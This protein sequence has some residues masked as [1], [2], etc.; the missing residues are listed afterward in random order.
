MNFS[1]PQNGA[2][3]ASYINDGSTLGPVGKPVHTPA[4]IADLAFPGKITLSKVVVYT[5]T[6]RA[7]ATPS[8]GLFEVQ[9]RVKHKSGKEGWRAAGWSFSHFDAMTLVL[10]QKDGLRIFK[11][12][13]SFLP[14]ESWRWRL[15]AA[16]DEREDKDGRWGWKDK[17]KEDKLGP[18]INEV[19]FRGCAR[20]AAPTT[21]P[22]PEATDTPRATLT[23]STTA[24]P[25]VSPSLTATLTNT[26]QDTPTFSDSPTP[27]DTRTFTITETARDSATVT[28]SPTV[29]LSATVT[30]T[31]SP[32]PTTDPTPDCSVF[33]PEYTA[34][35]WVGK[36][37]PGD[38]VALLAS[39]G[40]VLGYS[41]NPAQ[42]GYY[43][44]GTVP[45]RRYI[46]GAC[47]DWVDHRKLQM[48]FSDGQIDIPTMDAFGNTLGN[49]G[50]VGSGLDAPAVR[51]IAYDPLDGSLYA[52]ES[53]SGALWRMAPGGGTAVRVAEGLGFC[54]GMAFDSRRNLYVCSNTEGTISRVDVAVNPLSP[55]VT[56]IA[57]GMVQLM[58]LACDGKNNLY[59]T[60]NNQS[61]GQG[62]LYKIDLA[63]GNVQTFTRNFAPL[64]QNSGGSLWM[65]HGVALD[66]AGYIWITQ[67]NT[68]TN[69]KGLLKIDP[70]TGTPLQYFPL[71]RKV[72]QVDTYGNQ[73]VV[74]TVLGLPL[75]RPA[76]GEAAPFGPTFTPTPAPQVA[77]VSESDVQAQRLKD[78]VPKAAGILPQGKNL[79]ALP[80]PAKGRVKVVFKLQDAGKARLILVNLNGEV[81]A[82][83]VLGDRPAGEQSVDL[84]LEN[85]GPGVYQ[86]VLMADTGFGYTT[87][88]MFKL[89]VSY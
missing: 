3:P 1:L 29:W 16:G 34:T 48:S 63:T 89:A 77:V 14:R 41:F 87:K 45:G 70:Q 67:S 71:P 32:T 5:A 10:K 49:Y 69:E 50:T 84:G 79:L 7:S 46:S 64:A 30:K 11:L 17:D 61:T 80:N 51:G 39:N 59:A 12:E 43:Y 28:A 44:I 31:S 27:A 38:L 13:K 74:L 9:Y 68:A 75:P 6:Y 81:K 19:E 35:P 65:A 60:G 20:D 82:A 40:Q 23:D 8:F 47:V 62:F 21:V 37:Q 88:A 4:V 85:A 54:T 18:F 22:T 25:S 36:G 26:P 78:A 57:S 83:L 76:C 56:V 52:L 15:V 58:M 33:L 86:L 24:T 72:G 66:T 53:A 55:T 42:G 2:Q 73:V